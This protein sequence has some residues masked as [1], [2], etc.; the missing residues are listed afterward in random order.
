MTGYC[1]AAAVG[2]TVAFAVLYGCATPLACDLSTGFAVL[3]IALVYA[4]HRIERN[5]R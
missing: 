2:M 3:L 1:F 5:H 4:M